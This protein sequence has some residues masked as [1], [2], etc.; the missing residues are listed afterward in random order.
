VGE[1]VVGSTVGNP[2]GVTVVGLVDGDNMGDCEIG[3]VDCKSGN[4]ESDGSA[5][6]FAV[7]EL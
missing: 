1:I 3:P 4:K 2:L 6:P 5:T 7:V